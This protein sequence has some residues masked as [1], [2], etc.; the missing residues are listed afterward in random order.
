MPL[1]DVQ[2]ST[3]SALPEVL[4][5]NL[6]LLVGTTTLLWLVSLRLRDASIID[7]FWGLGFVIAAWAT[8]VQGPVTPA[9]ILLP[10]AVT[11]WGVRLSVYLG[12]RNLGHGED[13]RYA[14]MRA[15]R[16]RH[17]W[18]WSYLAIFLF[19]AIL[20]ALIGLP[21][22]VGQVA[23]RP[24]GLTLFDLA[25]GALF[26]FGFLYESIADWQLARFKRDP[27]N[28]GRV[29]DQGLWRHTRHPNYFGEA[30]LWWGIWLMASAAPDA[31]WTAIA[32]ALI[33]F[34]LL[35]V[36]GVSLLE[37]TIVDRRPAYADYI[38]R[39][40]AFLPGPRRR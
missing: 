18:W 28:A 9:S 38:R 24:E 11:L 32:P 15:A 40:N 36:S 27:A 22:V 39:T 33:T 31:R 29:M 7:L 25:G 4:G 34:L 17:F 3:L 10:A 16:P 12:A 13:R 5:V 20:C 23:T 6:A 1:P 35:R 8:R 26:L 14:A 30:V 21:A 2:A 37:S 19:Q